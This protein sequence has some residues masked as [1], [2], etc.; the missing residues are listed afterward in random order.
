[1]TR[2][3][4]AG[5]DPDTG[6]LRDDLTALLKVLVGYLERPPTA[7][8]FGS[9]LNA[10]ARD[11]ELAALQREISREARAD[12]ERALQ[13]GIARGDLAADVDIP[14]LIDLLIAPFLYRGIVEH[15][16]APMSDIPRVVDAVLAAFSASGPE[17]YGVG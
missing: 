2:L 14:F 4:R 11:P 9:F 3:R 15:T 1:M 7:R 10:A 6:S 8:V 13:R 12:Y 16:P 5:V 17:G